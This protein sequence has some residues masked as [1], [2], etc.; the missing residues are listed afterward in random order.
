MFDWQ[1]SFEPGDYRTATIVVMEQRERN[2]SSPLEYP[3]QD[4]DSVPPPS[5]IPF[6]SECANSERLEGGM[7][8][9]VRIQPHEWTRTLEKKFGRLILKKARGT[10]TDK[11]AAMLKQL[12]E[13]RRALLNRRTAEEMVTDYKRWS[14]TQMLLKALQKYVEV[15][16]K[17]RPI[18]QG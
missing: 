16:S 6:R 2:S 5:P 15:H 10:L 4:G 7:I 12:Q 14:V 8:Q 18:S 3:V 13:D 11:E 9:N 1:F 17:T